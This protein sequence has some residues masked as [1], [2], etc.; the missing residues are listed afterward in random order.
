MPDRPLSIHAIGLTSNPFRALTRDEWGRA[1]I[2]PEAVAR[3][4]DT[5]AHLQLLGGA[6]SGKTS[7]LLALGDRFNRAGMRTAYEHLPPK[8]VLIGRKRMA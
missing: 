3:A 7:C 8:C 2:L 1:V 6:G 5:G 4:A